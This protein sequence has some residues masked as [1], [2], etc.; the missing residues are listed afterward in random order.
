VILTVTP[1]PSVDR[2]WHVPGFEAGRAFRVEKTWLGAGG[3]GCNVAR[4]AAG[5]GAEVAATGF[6]AG[7]AGEFIER[8]L[9]RH[10]VALHRAGPGPPRRCAHLLPP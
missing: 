3:K 5:L 1:N 4:V 10:G 9:A 7:S 8:D 2:V 6:A